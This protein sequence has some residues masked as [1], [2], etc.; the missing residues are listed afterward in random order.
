MNQII[1]RIA[2][3]TYFNVK[4]KYSVII[5]SCFSV[6]YYRNLHN[7]YNKSNICSGFVNVVW[8]QLIVSILICYG[9][10]FFLS[11]HNTFVT[12]MILLDV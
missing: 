2:Y 6:N 8:A 5:P 3:S 4:Y 7:Q 1:H 9:F 10:K 11:Q 12:V